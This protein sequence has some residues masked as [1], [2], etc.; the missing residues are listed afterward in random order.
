MTSDTIVRVDPAT[1]L[2]GPNVR[3]EV[4]LSKEFV[5]S[6]K[7]LGVRV[8]ITA[9]ESAD[10]LVVI[11]GQRRTLAAVDAGVSSVPVFVTDAGSEAE[12]IVDQIVI[13]E[14]RSDLTRPDAIAAV[15]LFDMKVP[16]IAKRTGLPKEFVQSVVAVGSSDAAKAV[17]A[18]GRVSFGT[19]AVIAEFDDFPSEQKVL[20]KEIENRTGYNVDFKAR[21]LRDARLIRVHEEQLREAGTV[22]IKSPGWDQDDPRPLNRLFLD[23]GKTQRASDASLDDVLAKAGDGLRAYVGIGWADGQRVAETWYAVAG[24]ADRGFFGYPASGPAKPST[25]EEAEALKAERRVA[26]ET[27]KS[28]VTATALRI[29]F[30]QQLVGRRS[31]PAGWQQWVGERLLSNDTFPN[32]GWRMAIAILQLTESRDMYSMRAV[33]EK[34]FQ[35]KPTAAAQIM[36]ASALGAIEGG[37]EF[38]RKGWQQDKTKRYLEQLATW[39]YQLSDVEQQVVKPKR[40]RKAAA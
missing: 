21:E 40:A 13:N 6:I 11:D 26:R 10:G 35:E 16:A 24:W 5:A 33:V 3:K 28:W 37:F 15:A 8:P 32:N 29:E 22:V 31:A 25:P 7:E 9:H 18:D 27:T 12:R 20:L 14:Q 17:L 19:A 34:Y 23:K 2:V 38:D 30:L 4:E 39:G 36:L 1:L